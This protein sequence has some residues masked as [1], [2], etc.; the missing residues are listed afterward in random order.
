MIFGVW[1]NWIRLR[2]IM[3]QYCVCSLS[4]D[5]WYAVICWFVTFSVRRMMP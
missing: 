1:A 4:D 2:Y 5:C 3:L